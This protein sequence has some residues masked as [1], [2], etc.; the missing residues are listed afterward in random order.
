MGAVRRLAQPAHHGVSRPFN[1]T[2]AALLI[3][4]I[5]PIMFE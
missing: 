5:A 4:S 1:W 2:M 3:A